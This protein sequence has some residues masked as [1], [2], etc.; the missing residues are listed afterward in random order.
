MASHKR[1]RYQ[2]ILENLLSKD[3]AKLNTPLVEGVDVPDGS[4]GEGKVLVVDDQGSQL[5]GA[6]VAT[7]QD[8][9]G[10]AVAKEDLVGNKLLGGALG[11]DLVGGLADHQSFSLG[12]V[13]GGKHLLVDAVAD[14]VVALGGQDEV[15]G[16]ELGALVDELE[17]GV[18][19]VGAGLA[20]EDGAC[21][22]ALVSRRHV[23]S[24]S[25]LTG[26]VLCGGSVRGDG[27]AVGLHGKLLKNTPPTPGDETRHLRSNQVSLGLEEVRVPHAEETTQ[28]G[29][30]LLQGGLA[31]VL[32]HLVGTGKELVEVV[33]A[34]VDG[35]AE[36]DG[37][38]DGVTAADPA[39]EAEH[40]LGV[41]AELGDLLLVGGQGDKVL[42][43]IALAVRLLEEPRLGRVGV[44]GGLGG[45]E[46][47]GGD[48]EEGGL[49]V[50]VGEG[51]GHVGAVNVGDEVQGLVLG[52][53]VLEGL[54][55]HDGAAALCGGVVDGALLGEV[56]LLAGEH[57]VALLLDAGLLG[58]LNE[59]AEGLIGQE[60]LGEVEE[61]IG[62]RGRVLEGVGELGEAV[63]V[64]GE[65]LLEDKVLAD[66]VAVSLELGPRG[67]AGSLR[68][69][70]RSEEDRLLL[71]R[72]SQSSEGGIEVSSTG[73]L[74]A[75]AGG[76]DAM[77]LVLMMALGP[78]LAKIWEV[79]RRG[80]WGI[81]YWEEVREQPVVVVLL[82]T[83]GM[84][85]SGV[86]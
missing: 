70:E 46:G 34:D 38:P 37:A 24:A 53:V 65:G 76:S 17:E 67:K 14:G 84:D 56:D 27:L 42:G 40:V 10:R 74:G 15:G 52:T 8:A 72:G 51:L 63:R 6:N 55:D 11:A 44:G 43:D 30:V 9:G 22:V 26:G 73:S 20:E 25:L 69:F 36:A 32:V 50:R 61:D 13:V 21:H 54:G 39:L 3:L 60:V 12:K 19:G 81:K 79:W 66:I 31:E 57:G 29:D 41:D 49:G 35:D 78:E 23:A 85:E 68:H 71:G 83:S 18:L 5:G 58:E 86:P 47:L 1:P 59:E 28:D 77:T 82:G 64:V 4:L 45:G 16:D 75:N 7:D 62:A 48:E 2:H 33:V 80:G